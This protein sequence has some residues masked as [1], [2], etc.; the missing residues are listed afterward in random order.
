MK[1][2]YFTPVVLLAFGSLFLSCNNGKENRKNADIEIDS[3][4]GIVME[5]IDTSI[6]P[7]DN[8]FLFVNGAWYDRTEIPAEEG[9]WG[10]FNE[11]QEAN[12]TVLLRVL[13]NASNNTDEYPE[14]SDE[15]KAALFYKAGMDSAHIE[16][17]GIAPIVPIL[18]QING[19]KN[20]NDLQTVLADLHRQ[21]L[22]GLFHFF[23]DQ[24]LKQSDVITAYLYQGGLGM[25]DRDYYLKDDAKSKEIRKAYIEHVQKVLQ[26]LGDSAEETKKDAAII[27]D[28]ETQLA[29]SSMTRVEQ[30]NI[31]AL[32]NKMSLSEVSK[33]SP[34]FDWKQYFIDLGV[35]T[36]DTVIVAQPEF[37]K[38]VSKVV[39][40]R[41]LDEL[42]TYLKWHVANDMAPYLNHDFVQTSFHFY[43]TVLSGV[44]KMKPRWKRIISN[45]NGAVG[46]ALGKLYV[47]EAFPPEAKESAR[48]M[49][50]N[51]KLAFRDR[52]E[53]LD[54]MSSSTKAEALKKLDAFKVKIGYPD[55]WKEYKEL[56]L[57]ESFAE[58]VL[59]AN[60]FAFKKEVDKI[61]K[62]VDPTEW[63]MTPP[64][65]NAYY[66]PAMNEIV[67]PAGILQ[68]PFYD[69]KADAAVNY[70]G[71]GAVIGHELTH[72]FDDQGRQFDA[73]GNLNDWW[74]EED[75]K[76]FEERAQRLVE[77]FNQ[78]E[79][80]DSV[81]INGKLTLGENI[82]DLGGL[83]LAYDGLQRYLKE[84]GNP[85][86][87][88]G[89]T[90]EQRF[91]MSWA[92]VWRI[93]QRPETIRQLVMIDPHSPGNFRV[94]GPLS[95]LETF[96]EAF[97]VTEGDNMWRSDSVRAK[98]W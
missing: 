15:A 94:L 21:D 46:E 33:I 60:A 32:Y 11:L 9:R 90:P 37:F 7:A 96:Y 53:Q 93:K 76:R 98:I 6:D 78:Y 87:I 77:Q 70:G 41:S 80:L 51:I 67:F 63:A 47:A 81:F 91:F 18:E 19:I 73:E 28:I 8:F 25:P 3:T 55:K 27:M 66:N 31:P 22:K 65:V 13:T 89:Y 52:I 5:N 45:T 26:L 50:E 36:L 95:N 40:N 42:K 92:Q 23:V 74:S 35:S 20:S 88:N 24:D 84:H 79:A 57:G 69:Y 72:G 54:W 64:T 68:P 97:N 44:E 71:I 75:A 59:N 4:R 29:K 61:G 82:A 85:G 86:K 62:P 17:M 49:V 14:G 43:S 58:N 12:N 39:S 56:E 2:H 48:E 83:S 16:T 30:R 1:H 38:E 34:V 10:S